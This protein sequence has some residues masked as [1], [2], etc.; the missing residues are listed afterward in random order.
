MKPPS[1]LSPP[2]P[3][4]IMRAGTTRVWWPV[5]TEGTTHAR[6]KLTTT[7]DSIFLRGTNEVGMKISAC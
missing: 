1:P 6:E 3:P 2:P 7:D 5:G 4:N